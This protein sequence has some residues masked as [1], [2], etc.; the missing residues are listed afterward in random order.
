M[1]KRLLYIFFLVFIGCSQK[2]CDEFTIIG[3]ISNEYDGHMVMLFTLLNDSILFVDSTIIKNGGFQFKGKEYIRDFSNISLGKIPEKNFSTQLILERGKINVHLDSISVV[4]G[5]FLQT[6]YQSYQDSISLLSQKTYGPFFEAMNSGNYYEIIDDSTFSEMR[7][8]TNDYYLRIIKRNLNNAVGKKVFLNHAYNMNIKQLDELYSLFDEL[9]LSDK[10]IND[11]VKGKRMMEEEIERQKKLLGTVI[12][13]FELI[14]I[15]GKTQKISNY[16]RKSKYLYIDFWASW[17]V[18]C[19]AEI[20][21]LAKILQE[22]QN[23]LNILGISYDK[24]LEAMKGGVLKHTIPWETVLP[25]DGKEMEVAFAF[26]S[27][28]FSIFLDENGNILEIGSNGSL[29]LPSLMKK[30]LCIP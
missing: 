13:D 30:Y 22:H 12:Q 3:T 27:L 20:P 28:P 26:D 9:L 25:K 24:D 29:L 18:P 2:H 19:V 7:K 5:Q 16:L 6:L 10:N 11:V 1:K 4:S 23:C 14:T 15:D 8:K 21:V 17:C